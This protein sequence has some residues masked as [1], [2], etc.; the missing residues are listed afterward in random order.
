MDSAET[1]P[2]LT[3]EDELLAELRR[4]NDTVTLLVESLAR[5]GG[6]GN[7]R[8]S[9]TFGGSIGAWQVASVCACFFTMFALII[10]LIF[11]VPQLHDLQAWEGVINRDVAVIKATLPKETKP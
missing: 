6:F 1:A 3:V 5:G 10:A 8:V 11:I 2:V 7:A 9:Q 4:T